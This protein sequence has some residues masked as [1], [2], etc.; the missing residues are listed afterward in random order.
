MDRVGK[1]K[2]I[3][4]RLLLLILVIGL[5][6]GLHSVGGK[7]SEAPNPRP[8]EENSLYA[9]GGFSWQEYLTDLI[10]GKILDGW[11]PCISF[12]E[13]RFLQGTAGITGWSG[14][15]FPDWFSLLAGGGYPLLALGEET[16]G[17]QTESGSTREKILLQEGASEDEESEGGEALEV[18]RE[19]EGRIRLD[20][21]TARLV[22]EENQTGTGEAD[23]VLKADSVSANGADG[24][25]A[26]G[27]D[28]ISDNGTA[29]ASELSPE[30]AQQYDWNYY[31]DFDALIGEFYAVDAATRADA[32]RISLDNLLG[33]DMSIQTDPALPQIL[34]YHTHSQEAF[35]DSVPG[36][37]STSIVGAGETLARILREEYGY[38][39][40]HHCGEYD[41]ESRD[42][43]YSKA[44]P[45]LE[46]LLAQNPSI[47]V[48]ID[49]HRDEMPEGRKLVTQLNGKPTARFMFF[50]GL[51]YTNAA[52]NIGYL[53]NPYID[54][55]LAFSFQL[56]VLANEYYPDLT[57]RIYLKGYR[58]NMHLL[59]RSLLIELGAQTNTVEEIRN[60]CA[61]IARIL[62]MVLSG[63][64]EF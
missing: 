7:K 17:I 33:R 9:A 47:Q 24:I 2:K 14:S 10:C 32:D 53:E 59:P 58:Y 60:A 26:D 63:K 12:S 15:G 41:V 3:F 22:Q 20:D 44:L 38:N 49:L 45:A 42:Y 43:A 21:E 19:S 4:H 40:L 56:Q 55:N 51:S 13:Y 29:S 64:G 6:D 11:L 25:A 23:G 52:G 37:S 34:I 36:D 16:V 35:A 18:P 50:N 48:I 62:D 8:E 1:G 46:Q 28:S 31:R 27:T 30:K 39:V 5:A 57:R 61:P 54:E